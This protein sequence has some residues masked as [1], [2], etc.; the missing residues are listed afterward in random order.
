ME[1]IQTLIKMVY[2]SIFSMKIKIKFFLAFVIIILILGP[3]IGIITYSLSNKV[4]TDNTEQ[5]S[6]QIAD[7]ISVN[8]EY[9]ANTFEQYAYNFLSESKSSGVSFNDMLSSLN[10]NQMD[11]NKNRTMSNIISTYII[12]NNLPVEKLYIRSKSGG[13]YLWE[14][15]DVGITKINSLS[16]KS[17][18]SYQNAFQTLPSAPNGKLWMRDNST[19]N[20][21]ILYARED[22]DK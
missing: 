21:Y 3:G 17:M 9:Q 1:K 6:C 18:K 11:F 4:I 5:L 22:I 8:V 13:V 14:K 19:G 20:K 12:M 15:N 7:Q 2:K 10:N 16:D